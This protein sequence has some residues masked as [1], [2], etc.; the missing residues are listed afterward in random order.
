[1][2]GQP[3][4]RMDVGQVISGST[5]SLDDD[6]RIRVS[7]S[8]LWSIALYLLVFGLFIRQSSG[9]EY[10]RLIAWCGIRGD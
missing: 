9:A 3:C 2:H 7:A 5:S 8:K 4:Q 10:R 6:S 1:M